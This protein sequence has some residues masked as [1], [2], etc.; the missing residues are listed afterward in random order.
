MHISPTYPGLLLFGHNTIPKTQQRLIIT[1]GSASVFLLLLY[2]NE[3]CHP[4][5]LV[6]AFPLP[7]IKPISQRAS[8]SWLDI[9]L[10]PPN[11]KYF[12]INN[13]IH[14]HRRRHRRFCLVFALQ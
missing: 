11:A 6:Q 14:Y 9:R 12:A 5:I 2:R 3:E 10:E 7:Y 8:K 1:R 4:T 13:K